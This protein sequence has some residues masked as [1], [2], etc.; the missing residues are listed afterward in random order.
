MINEQE[1]SNPLEDIF[2]SV[3]SMAIVYGVPLLL[4]CF[5]LYYIYGVVIE[6][7][8]AGVRAMAA[9]LL[10]LSLTL[11]FAKSNV[12]ENTIVFLSDNRLASFGFA[13]V[14]AMLTAAIAMYAGELNDVPVG[15]LTFSATL[16]LMVFGND[17]RN[18]ISFL[19]IGAVSGFL[20]YII[21]FGVNF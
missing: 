2:S 17:K 10:P 19:H 5:G 3:L 12:R 6:D 13:F 11:A 15:V 8:D 16:A 4:M 1:Q 20:M 14:M 9:A 18:K 21:I 7:M